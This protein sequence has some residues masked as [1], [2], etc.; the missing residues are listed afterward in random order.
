MSSPGNNDSNPPPSPREDPWEARERLRAKYR[1]GE[2]HT[3]S[4]SKSGSSRRS[5]GDD[6]GPSLPD[7]QGLSNNLTVVG[8]LSALGM[9]LV[10][11]LPRLNGPLRKVLAQ[12][13]TAILLL[14]I[15][16][17]RRWRP[18]SVR[19][20]L[21]RAPHL[22]LFAL[23]GWVV[24]EFVRAPYKEYAAVEL[25]RVLA[26]LALYILAAYSLRTPRQAG[27]VVAGLLAIGTAISLWDIGRVGQTDLA[28]RTVIDF[29]Y[30][31]FGTHE[32]VASLLVLLLPLALSI[33]LST[34][35][36][37]K[38]RLAATASA[39]VLGAALLIART[40]S[41]WAGGLVSLLV[42]ALLSLLVSRFGVGSRDAAREA[43][44]AKKRTASH[45]QKALAS[46]ATLLALGMLVFVLIGGA[47][48]ILSLRAGTLKRITG[49]TSF[50]ARLTA[51][52]GAARMA[53]EQPFV[54]WGLG[55]YPVIQGQWTHQGAEVQTVL[56]ERYGHESIAHDYYLQWMAD[57]GAVGLTLYVMAIGSFLLSA[58]HTLPRVTSPF[59]RALLL[60]S[61]AAVAGSV[62][63]AIG[64]PAYNFFGVS[65]VLWLCMGLGT[66]AMGLR[67][68]RGGDEDAAASGA[69]PWWVWG[70]AA[71]AG[72]AASYGIL[73]AGF[74]VRQKGTE[75]PRGVLTVTLDPAGCVVPGQRIRWVA[76]Y[77]DENGKEVSTMPGTV[78]ELSGDPVVSRLRVT[79]TGEGDA[80]FAPTRSILGAVAPGARAPL[81]IHAVY[82]DRYGRR[83]EAW[84]SL[85]VS[86]PPPTRPHP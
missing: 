58:V 43:D 28:Q 8:I 13:G 51:W 67:G 39:I 10:A 3:R 18:V 33:A 74:H 7:E 44:G 80:L 12:L 48:P 63:D 72:I 83:Y 26:G 54:G 30:S 1:P 64:S 42:L 75:V 60:G 29:G 38:R 19:S 27:Y 24:F 6:F 35:V 70:A 68:R 52:E 11:E 62:V 47:L 22:P 14:L 59:A 20:T 61:A 85:S 69:T 41:A 16:G 76:R 81:T 56:H 82:R 37:E 25:L 32:D 71:G 84:S 57:N 73:W 45:W 31:I 2:H 34:E 23:L 36:E 4:S 50:T 40:R 55:T 17:T 5:H 79:L 49:D 77:H 9:L 15:A 86:L 66:A 46:P 53:S 78:W 21:L 65:S